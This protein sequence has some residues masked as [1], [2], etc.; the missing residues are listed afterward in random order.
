MLLLSLYRS[1]SLSHSF[2]SLPPF[3]LRLPISISLYS[4]C[5]PSVTD[6]IASPTFFLPLPS[7]PCPPIPPL[8]GCGFFLLCSLCHFSSCHPPIPSSILC[9]LGDLSHHNGVGFRGP[10]DNAMECDTPAVGKK[11]REERER[12]RDERRGVFAHMHN[13]GYQYPPSLIMR[14]VTFSLLQ[15]YY[16]SPSYFLTLSSQTLCNPD[17]GREKSVKIAHD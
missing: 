15:E 9:C 11:E 3:R 7:K 6:S 2:P 8:P 17:S 12:K 4:S 1:L 10:A 13:S 16:T 5:H 14:N